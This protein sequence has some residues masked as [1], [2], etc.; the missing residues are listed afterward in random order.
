MYVRASSRQQQLMRVRQ[1]LRAIQW[2]RG[3]ALRKSQHGHGI[4]AQPR[5]PAARSPALLSERAMTAPPGGAGSA[6]LLLGYDTTRTAARSRSSGTAPAAAAEAV[7]APA[8]EP[9]PSR[10]LSAFFTAPASSAGRPPPPFLPALPPAAATAADPAG[11]SAASSAARDTAAPRARPGK[12]PETRASPRPGT[13][14][15]YTSLSRP[16]VGLRNVLFLG[17]G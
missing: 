9:P 10:L 8:T 6:W 12:S 2:P 3:A 13:S 15:T 7:S 5:Q 4:S 11:P 17:G 1:S 16:V 14:S